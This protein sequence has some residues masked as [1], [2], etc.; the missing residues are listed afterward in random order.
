MKKLLSIHILTTHKYKNRQEAQIKTWLQGFND[1]TFY[2]DTCLEELPNQI[3]VSNDDSY[4]GCAD[5]QVNEI[6]RIKDYKLYDDFEWF[7]FCDDDTFVN[8]NELKKFC[9]EKLEAFDTC[10]KVG[11]SWSSDP[12]LSYY[13]GG[14]GFLLRSD[15]IKNSTRITKK[16]GV[17]FSD[18]TVGLWLRENNVK[19]N[20]E[21]KFNSHPP[22][23]VNKLGYEKNEITFHYIKEY[24]V[25]KAL[26]EVI[27]YE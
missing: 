12:S 16:N 5:K 2:T 26:S 25:M 21:S 19:V 1:F 10:G 27:N 7:F 9:S 18:V 8:L 23:T 4:A 14:A 22:E 3:S 6:N 20:H 13:S 15:F 17:I 11:N 24:E